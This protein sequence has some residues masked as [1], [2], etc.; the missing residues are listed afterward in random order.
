MLGGSAEIVVF[1]M[2]HELV[3]VFYVDGVYES[4]Q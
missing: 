3:V 1:E 4:R 2:G